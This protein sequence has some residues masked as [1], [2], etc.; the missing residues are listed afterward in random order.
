[1]RRHLYL[2]LTLALPI[3]CAGCET[4]AATMA[5]GT[6]FAFG[7]YYVNGSAE[8]TVKTPLAETE[9]VA[10]DTLK[11]FGMRIMSATQTLEEKQVVQ[12]DFRA[13]VVG[14]E[15]ESVTISLFKVSE[16]A[17]RLR[18][19]A[20]KGWLKPD[21]PTAEAILHAMLRELNPLTVANYGGN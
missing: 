11:D 16:R 18:V 8:E 13:G 4:P 9:P 20:R 5:G 10:H 6:M 1:M 3:A 7:T 2:L 15:F 21:Y 12:T 14:E 17:T 19:V